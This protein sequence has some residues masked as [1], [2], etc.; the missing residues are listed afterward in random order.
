MEVFK[1]L[2]KSNC[3][4]C[5]EVTCLAFASKVF[6]GVKPLDM[7]PSIDPE[8]LK[9]YS[10]QDHKNNREEEQDRIMDALKQQ[11]ARL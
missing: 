4:K 10:G 3:R 2:D 7:C 9:Q 1:L 8:I 6:M 11:L 5:N